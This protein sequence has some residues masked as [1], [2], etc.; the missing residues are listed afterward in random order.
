LRKLVLL[1]TISACWPVASVAQTND[2]FWGPWTSREERFAATLEGLGGAGVA[3]TDDAAAA[4]ANPALLATLT[5]SEVLAG[6]ATRN[7]TQ[8]GTIGGGGVL[9]HGF[10][11]GGY[12]QRAGIVDAPV[13]GGRLDYQVTEGAA[14]AAKQF[15]PLAFGVGVRIS[16]LALSGLSETQEQEG[17]LLAG[18][19]A[20]NT[21]LGALLGL[22]Y[23]NE[24]LTLGVSYRTRD[25]YE[26]TRTSQLDRLTDDAGSTY[27]V[28]R[29]ARFSAGLGYRWGSKAGF[30]A[31]A[32]FRQAGM[33]KLVAH[34][35]PGAWTEEEGG[36]AAFR[37]GA[38]YAVPV[39]GISVLLRGGVRHT[40][41]AGITSSAAGFPG[42]EGETAVAGG[43]SLVFKGGSLDVGG[44]KGGV[45]AEGRLRF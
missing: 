13:A 39:N 36:L 16:R 29:P 27:D 6:V 7:A 42:A 24:G 3:R 20:G 11:L 18:S 22:A 10:A 4:T 40:A 35:G 45:T 32:D 25:T 34:R 37:A 30:F 23:V 21:R 1:V 17:P 41:A 8:F 2:A 26:A 43:L 5:R 31:Q 9:R 12:V 14:L 28:Q 33:V 15:G 44:S 19:A 38:E